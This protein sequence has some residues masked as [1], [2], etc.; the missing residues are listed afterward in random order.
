MGKDETND[1]ARALIDANL[2]RVFEEQLEADLPDS[3]K[4]LLE[5]LRAQSD[6]NSQDNQK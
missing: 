5:Q 2:K 1:K 3:L 6:G 4:D